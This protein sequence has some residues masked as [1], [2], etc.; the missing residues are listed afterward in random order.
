V[1]SSIVPRRDLNENEL[2][3]NQGIFEDLLRTRLFT[4]EVLPFGFRKP[5]ALSIGDSRASFKIPG[6]FVVS[7]S[8]TGVDSTWIVTDLEILVRGVQEGGVPLI[9]N[10]RQIID[11]VAIAQQK[12]ASGQALMELYKYL[13]IEF[14]FNFQDYFCLCLKLEILNS[15]AA[16]LDK[17]RWSSAGLE[18]QLD[19]ET[20]ALKLMYWKKSQASSLEIRIV[21]KV[22]PLVA[23]SMLSDED[24]AIVQ[25]CSG[26]VGTDWW[27]EVDGMILDDGDLDAERILIDNVRQKAR[28]LIQALYDALVS[29]DGNVGVF[30]KENV[31]IAD[32]TNPFDMG[33]QEGDK[34]LYIGYNPNKTVVCSVE[35][36]TGLFVLDS[37]QTQVITKLLTLQGR[38]DVFKDA[39]RELNANIRGARDVFLNLRSLTVKERVGALAAYRSLDSVSTLPVRDASLVTSLVGEA[40]VSAHVLY[41]GV[42]RHPNWYI[43]VSIDGDSEAG[44][45]ETRKNA[46]EQVIFRVW[47]VQTALSAANLL[48]SEIVKSISIGPKE[49]GLDGERYF[50]SIDLNTFARLTGVVGYGFV[51]CNVQEICC[52]VEIG[53]ADPRLWTAVSK[54]Q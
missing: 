8:L 40:P 28:L 5:G 13:R 53:Y 10:E 49:L 39:E 21:E 25:G 41:L 30:T 26:P 9:L 6:E 12:I 19:R 17:S 44:G 51:I 34:C 33:G 46:K 35:L 38:E 31:R 50:S 3:V 27:I 1:K 48:S 32:Y 15:Q 2:L 36:Q 29:E 18:S 45:F 22:Y 52:V 4:K 20:G 42:P 37:P 11:V 16:Y 54:Y 47:C 23:I 24:A 43:V 7:V 14:A